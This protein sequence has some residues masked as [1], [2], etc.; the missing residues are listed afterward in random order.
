M[1]TAVKTLPPHPSPEQYRTQAK[2]LLKAWKSGDSDAVSR[3]RKFHVRRDAAPALAGAQLVLAREH[4]FQSWPKFARH[5]AAMNLDNSPESRFESAAHAVV[6]GDVATLE[7][8]LRESPGLIRARSTRAHRAT[9]LHYMGANGVE[10]FRQKTPE[11][12]VATLRVLLR[13]GAEIDAEADMY[14]RDT[15]LGLVATSVHPLRAGVQAELMEVLL[16]AGATVDPHGRAVVDCLA[17]GRGHAAEFLAARGAHLDLEGAAG[18]GR[19]DLAAALLPGAARRQIERG[20]L[21]ACEYGRNDVVEFLLANGADPRAQADVGQTGLHMAVIGGRIDTVR[22]LV[23]HGAPLEEKNR[24]GGTALGQA[25]WCAA[26]GDPA[27]DYATIADLL[28][29][30]GARR[31]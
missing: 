28:I 22:L 23:A 30:S 29:A 7:R 20:F 8:L 4:G 9:L 24:Y 11:N 14:H 19:L 16:A 3:V 27:A 10:D 25:R 21:W 13:A 15:T 6:T 5:I 2:D 17:N 1:I 12:A 26:N 31:S 18:V